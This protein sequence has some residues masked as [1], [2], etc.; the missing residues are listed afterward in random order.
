MDR[1]T[2]QRLTTR[3]QNGD[4]RGLQHVFD[5]THRYCVR[6]M[7]KKTRCEEADAEDIF[8]D[9]MLIFRENVLSGKLQQL[10]NVRTYVFGICWNLWRDLN[11]A[12]ARWGQP[13]SESERQA[14]L[15]A[16]QDVLQEEEEKELMQRRLKQ[17][18]TAL[19]RLG[20]KCRQL[21]TYVYMEQRPQQEI[22]DLMGFAS[23]NV[24]KV[25][26]HR[27]FEQWVRHIEDTH[28]P[29]HGKE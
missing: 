27:C 18:H 3:I 20:E 15:I 2:F 6:T 16:A 8:M 10:S 22:A 7:I 13:E 12:K 9:A 21:L 11:R 29:A 19:E 17:V 24:V 5:E 26:R 23:A 1:Q 25:T 14:M 4:P 28:I